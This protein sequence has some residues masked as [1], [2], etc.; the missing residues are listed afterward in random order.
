MATKLRMRL[1]HI[2]FLLTRPM[3]LGVRALAFDA[4][5]RVLLVK[6]TYVDGWHLPGGG[7]ETGETAMVSLARELSEEANVEVA[8]GTAPTLFG[9]Y[10]NRTSSPRDHVV[11]YVYKDVAQNAPKLAD[12][13]IVD[14]RFFAV[15]DLPADTSP[16]TR[17][18][19]TEHL[20]GSAPAD[21]W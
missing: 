2:W 11:V 15:D 21:L 1:F 18:R 3:T 6:H 8:P 9:V 12:R 16:A 13:E 7:V 17:R 20:S 10:H 5:D 14:A 19:I 4:Q